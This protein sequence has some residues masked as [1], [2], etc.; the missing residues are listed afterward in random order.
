LG[1]PGA[2]ETSR[3]RDMGW[4]PYSYGYIMLYVWLPSGNL[5]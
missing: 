3:S 5:T 2:G 4:C 1:A